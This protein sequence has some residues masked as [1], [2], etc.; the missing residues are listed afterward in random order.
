MYVLSPPEYLHY[1]KNK[2]K[3]YKKYTRRNYLG[4][5]RFAHDVDV[6]GNRG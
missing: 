5:L 2:R 1:N 3:T 4:S 6:L